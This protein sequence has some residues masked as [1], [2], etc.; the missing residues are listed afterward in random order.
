VSDIDL[1][2]ALLLI[3]G[4]IVALVAFALWLLR[5]GIGLKT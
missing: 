2:V 5:R 4:F 1:P 3:V